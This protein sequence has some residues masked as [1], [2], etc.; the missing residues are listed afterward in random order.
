M[1]YT[2]AVEE[3]TKL[4][5]PWRR[6]G[7]QQPACLAGVVA[8]VFERITDRLRD[9]GVGGKVDHRVC[10]VFLQHASHQLSVTHLT[11]DQRSVTHSLPEPVDRLSMTTT[12][13]PRSQQ[14]LYRVAA[15][16]PRAASDQN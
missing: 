9:D 16:I 1:P 10:L 2:A 15:D 5:T 7:G 8:I 14:L 11:H 6:A 3:N 12:D 4:R 13:S